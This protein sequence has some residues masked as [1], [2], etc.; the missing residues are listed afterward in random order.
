V[1]GGVFE[2]MSSHHPLEA[3]AFDG[4]HFIDDTFLVPGSNATTGPAGFANPAADDYRP[5]PGSV[6][7]NRLTDPPVGVDA[8]GHPRDLP[9]SLGAFE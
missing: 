8:E 1:R 9:A 4:N 5:I 3:A 2:S 6:L 7:R